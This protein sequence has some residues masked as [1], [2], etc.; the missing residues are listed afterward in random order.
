L[1]PV[2]TFPTSDPA[3]SPPFVTFGDNFVLSL[4][5]TAGTVEVFAVG[6]SGG[7]PNGVLTPVGAPVPTG[8]PGPRPTFLSFN[9]RN[10]VFYMTNSNF[11]G[12]TST[13]AAFRLDPTTDA[14]TA[15][16]TPISTNDTSD[17]AILHTSGRFLLQARASGFQRFAIDPTTFAPTLQLDVTPTEVIGVFNVDFSG[18]Y[19]YVS[20]VNLNSVSLHRIDAMT[21]AMTLV[22]T[23]PAGTQPRS[24][25]AYG[26]QP[27]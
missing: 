17:S 10:H 24:V 18:K 4:A 14:V 13:L 12:T 25:S 20:N 2:G 11:G 15:I 21:G 23:E 5:R 22:D 26:F 27:Q 19:L 16:G 8:P 3:P 7:V 9:R 1:T 6:K